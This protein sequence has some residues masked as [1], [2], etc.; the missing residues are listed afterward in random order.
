MNFLLEEI[1]D[2]KI[3]RIKEERLDSNVAPDLKTQLLMLVN[4][5][6]KV[7]VELSNIKYADSSGLGALL[8]GLRQARD[9]GGF[10]TV[11]GATKRVKS[12]LKIA[13]LDG[14]LIN[15]ENEIEAIENMK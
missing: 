10:F 6:S 5:K 2:V 9:N 7:V 12:L 3:L 14:M 1:D 8:L 15:Y 11:C 13:Q 4:D